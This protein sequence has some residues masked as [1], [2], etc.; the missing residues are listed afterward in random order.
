MLAYSDSLR[1]ELYE[2]KNIDVINCQPGYINTNVSI[3]A[4]TS[5]G[6]ANNSNDDDHRLGFD[7]NYVGQMV[8]D[9]IVNREKEVLITIFLH[10][11][12][13]WARFF[14]PNIFSAI[15]YKRAKTTFDKKFQ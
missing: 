15:M 2:H 3:N 11:L 6:N 5:E 14:L 13:I 10:R 12:A 4:L 8:I 9:S 7:P 1:A